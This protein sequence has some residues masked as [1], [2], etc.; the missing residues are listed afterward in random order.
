MH[1]YAAEAELSFSDRLRP[2][3]SRFGMGGLGISVRFAPQMT[4]PPDFTHSGK[5]WTF[6]HGRC[7]IYAA[8]FGTVQAHFG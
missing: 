3:L 1:D 6:G 2:C 4:P 8:L 5:T 7:C